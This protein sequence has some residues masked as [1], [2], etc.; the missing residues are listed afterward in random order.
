MRSER[1]SRNNMTDNPKISNAGVRA[2]RWAVVVIGASLGGLDAVT[3][4]LAGLP[5]DFPVPVVV[6]QHRGCDTQGLLVKSLQQ[7]CALPLREPDDK[8]ALLAR[9]VYIAPA[10]YH[11]YLEDGGFSLSTDAPVNYSRP[12]IDVL[13]ESAADAYGNKTIAVILTGA[14][15]DGAQGA[16]RIKKR[17][18]FLIVQDPVT[19][20]SATMPAAAIAAAKP[21]AILPLEEIAGYLVKIVDSE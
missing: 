5:A 1:E 11:M 18:G 9:Q 20:E 6:V 12:S 21:D 17:G 15:E 3:A 16:A 10:D 14:N 2:P 4:L 7:H 13:F 8:E 19:A